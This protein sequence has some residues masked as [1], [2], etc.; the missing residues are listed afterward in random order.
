M[1]IG[2]A[3]RAVDPGR[4]AG[5]SEIIADA[6]QLKFIAAPLTEPQASELVKAP[7]APVPGRWVAGKSAF[8]ES[9]GIG[10]DSIQAPLRYVLLPQK[11]RAC[12]IAS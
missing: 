9:T 4:I 7:C 6:V 12:A 8:R 1:P 3:A 11:F 10:V 5:M 2:V